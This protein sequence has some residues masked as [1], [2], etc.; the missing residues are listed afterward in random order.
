MI[1][2]QAITLFAQFSDTF[3]NPLQSVKVEGAIAAQET[4][5]KSMIPALCL[6]FTSS[7]QTDTLATHGS[8]AQC[9]L[10]TPSS[11]KR[12]QA[13]G[14]VIAPTRKATTGGHYPLWQHC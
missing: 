4:V 13:R 1:L 3:A 9:T 5:A 14:F 6:T 7:F 8:K 11:R 2:M 12:C 10:T